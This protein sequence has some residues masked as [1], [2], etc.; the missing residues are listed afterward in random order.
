MSE[1][2]TTLRIGTSDIELKHTAVSSAVVT[3]CGEKTLAPYPWSE[4]E[5][6]F[7]R[8]DQHLHIISYYLV[9]RAQNLVPFPSTCFLLSFHPE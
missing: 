8:F 7:K 1:G 9:L 6:L 5:G 3:R 4:I 2:S